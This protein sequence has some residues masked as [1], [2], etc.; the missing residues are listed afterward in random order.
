VAVA[1]PLPGVGMHSRQQP[2][3]VAGSANSNMDE[4]EGVPSAD[5]V[6]LTVT[7]AGSSASG[8]VFMFYDRHRA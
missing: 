7:G 1:H 6:T 3:F 2:F 5:Y 4:T 8:T